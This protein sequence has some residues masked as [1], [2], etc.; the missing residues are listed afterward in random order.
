[1]TQP[2]LAVFDIDGVL[3]DV[4][5]RLHHVEARPKD[6]ESFFAAMDD[7]APLEVGIALAHDQVAAGHEIAYLTGRDESYRGLTE[8]W[9]QRHGLP[10]GRLHM[11][12]IGDRRPARVM[13]PEALRRLARTH[14]VVAVVDDDVA[15][16]RV[17]RDGGWPVLHATWMTE[18]TPDAEQQA[19]FDAQELE[20][21]S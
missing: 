16:V 12:R 9:L 8:A 15:V 2:T 6:W 13:K 20:G 17:L 4:R 5:H 7:D 18:A 21:R 10:T 19:L 14:R 3:A 11:R 1:V